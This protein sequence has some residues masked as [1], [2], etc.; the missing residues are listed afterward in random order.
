MGHEQLLESF[1]EQSTLDA[2]VQQVPTKAAVLHRS[3]VTTRAEKRMARAR[4]HRALRK[5][6]GIVSSAALLLAGRHGSSTSTTTVST[7][8]S[9]LS[10]SWSQD[11]HHRDRSIG[12]LAHEYRTRGE[13]T[14]SPVMASAGSVS[15]L[16]QQSQCSVSILDQVSNVGSAIAD[17]QMIASQGESMDESEGLK[18]QVGSTDKTCS[19]KAGWKH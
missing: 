10:T 14:L 5:W 2:V 7:S 13:H 4:G 11:S 15:L 3:H 12:V 6:A 9:M 19:E 18:K 8:S 16:E 17:C 1:S